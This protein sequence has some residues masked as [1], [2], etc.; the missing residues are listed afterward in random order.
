[1][2]RSM[3]R[4]RRKKHKPR[5]H[6]NYN[7]NSVLVHIINGSEPAPPPYTGPDRSSFALKPV[8]DMGVSKSQMSPP[9]NSG[10]TL[11]ASP[12]YHVAEM[13]TQIGDGIF[14]RFAAGVNPSMSIGI[15][16]EVGESSQH[17][18]D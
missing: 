2:Q 9:M 14:D 1:M 11:S 6:V 17:S 13:Q 7:T 4:R 15:G 16:F 12:V 5:A 10:E 8:F 3:Q 18:Y